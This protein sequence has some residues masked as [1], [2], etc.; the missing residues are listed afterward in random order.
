MGVIDASE[1]GRDELLSA[2]YRIPDAPPAL[3]ALVVAWP[4]LLEPSR[5]GILAMVRADAITYKGQNAGLIPG[6]LHPVVIRRTVN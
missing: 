4:T 6:L 3:A 5:A 1:P 2:G